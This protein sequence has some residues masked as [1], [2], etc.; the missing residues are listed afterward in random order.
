MEYKKIC[1]IVEKVFK[2]EPG[3]TNENTKSA[4]IP[5]WDSLGH[6]LLIDYLDENFDEITK[7]KKDLAIATSIKDLYES[8]LKDL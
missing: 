8:G 7:K 3:S 4:D 6:F 1:N 2:L 5:E